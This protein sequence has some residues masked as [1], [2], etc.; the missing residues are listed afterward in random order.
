MRG[1]PWNGDTVRPLISTTRRVPRLAPDRRPLWVFTVPLVDGRGV[2]V[3]RHVVGVRVPRTCVGHWLDEEIHRRA[4][5]TLIRRANV[6][7]SALARQLALQGDRE[8]AL[9]NGVRRAF[10]RRL[11]QPGLFDTRATRADDAR[12][13]VD[14]MLDRQLAERLAL[15]RDRGVVRV[16]RARLDVRFE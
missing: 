11:F 12:K 10:E 16:G 14:V 15:L 5:A 3:E 7:R 8:R 13:A 2:T 4:A 9:T 1:A 6:V